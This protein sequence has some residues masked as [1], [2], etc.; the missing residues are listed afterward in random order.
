M[1]NHITASP[2]VYQDET[3]IRVDMPYDP[4]LIQ[5]IRT[6]SGARWS[7]DHRCWHVPKTAEAWRQLKAV[8]GDIPVVAAPEPEPPLAPPLPALPKMPASPLAGRL[9]PDKITLLPLPAEKDRMGLHLPAGLVPAHLAT[10]KNIH[11]RRWDPEL[12]VWRIPCTKLT[13]RFLDKYFPGMLD[14]TFQPAADLPERLEETTP[15]PRNAKAETPPVRYEEAVTALEQ[16]LMLKR[17]SWRTVKAYKNCFQQFI[18]HYDHIKPS[19]LTRKQ[20]D[21][22]V[23]GLIREK[24]ISESHQNQILSAIKMFYTEVVEQEH[25]VQGLFRPKRSQKLPQVLTEG[26]VTRLLQATQNL[27]HRCILMLIYSAGL[28]LG[29]VLQLRIADLQPENHRIFIRDGKGKK[30]R[31]TILSDKV[32]AKLS[33]YFELYQPVEWVFEGE[34][35]GRYS[36]R[37]VQKIF[38]RAKE[39]SKINPYA[40]VHT[41]HSFA[42]HLLE[43]GVDLRYIQDLLGHE[44]S[45]TTEIYTHITRKGMDKIRSPLDDLD[46]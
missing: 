7:P 6:V 1:S 43:K 37:S 20:I 19:Q 36:E 31:C 9:A 12:K 16:C 45:K 40:T 39:Q 15:P 32:F 3:R 28:R 46:L 44:S 8:F 11:G 22:Y 38:T 13:V 26:E 33:E 30:D 35:G 29:E 34:Q 25:K 4:A 5:Q 2:M 41:L 21:D 23:A 42:T 24:H 10:V 18:R 27:K 17:Y 14:W